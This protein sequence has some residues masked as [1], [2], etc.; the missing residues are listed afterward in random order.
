MFLGVISSKFTHKY[1]WTCAYKCN[2]LAGESLESVVFTFDQKTTPG[3]RKTT[4]KTR[5]AGDDDDDDDND[6]E[7]DNN[8]VD[9][10]SLMYLYSYFNVN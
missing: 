9:E 4:K 2:E 8:D 3:V 6:D 10:M 7:E 5:K 1:A